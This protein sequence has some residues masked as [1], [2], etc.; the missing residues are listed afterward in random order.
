M[1]VEFTV[2]GEARGKQRPRMTRSGHTYTPKETVSYENL[3]KTCYTGE[4]FP[5]GSELYIT[6]TAYFAIPKSVSKKKREE[7]LLDNI[8]PTKKP[9]CDNLAKSVCDAL[10]GIAYRDDSMIVGMMVYK[11]YAEAPRVDVAIYDR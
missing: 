3:V 8:R 9:D 11:K 4:Y 6:I 10:N 1:R 2:P 7:M 5:D